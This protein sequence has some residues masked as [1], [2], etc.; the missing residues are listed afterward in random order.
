MKTEVFQTANTVIS[1]LT[2]LA[3]NRNLVFRGYS[4]QAELLPKIIREKDLSNREI[5][6][7]VDFEKYGLQY[8]SVNNAIDFMSYA[9]H[10][11]LPTRLLD[12]TYNPFIALFFALFK[13]K[14][15]RMLMLK[16]TNTTTYDT[17]ILLSRLF[18]TLC[19]R[20]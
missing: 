13:K 14:E 6:L 10:F 17:V 1:A 12:F 8:F 20:L 3:K 9:Q 19:Q 5:E 4:K 11:G 15:P 16:I 7:L 2:D 18:L